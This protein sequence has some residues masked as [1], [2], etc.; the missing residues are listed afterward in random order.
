VFFLGMYVVIHFFN[1]MRGLDGVNEAFR[2]AGI[3]PFRGF[4]T[5]YALNAPFVAVL[6]LPF[7]ILMGAMW[8]V[9]HM[10]RRN[11]V[12]PVLSAGVSL[13]RMVLPLLAAGFLMSIL[14]AA[15]R[16]RVLP[17]LA[18]QRDRYDSLIKGQDSHELHEIPILIDGE[19]RRF[20]IGSY[21]VAA[22]V[23]R[24]ATLLGITSQAGAEAE[25]LAYDDSGPQ[26]PGWYP[27]PGTEIRGDARVFLE[28]DLLPIDLEAQSRGLLYL[29]VPGIRRLIQRDPGRPRLQVMLQTQYS[30]P[31]NGLI[32]LLLGLPLA[33]RTERR[34]PFIAAGMALLL[35]LV[36]F[37]VQSIVS[38]VGA[39][40]EVL[41]PVL[42]AWLPIV[43]F[44]AL[45]LILFESMRT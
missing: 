43:V 25:A 44:G 15:V 14:A 4:V 39:K 40:G 19:G 32:L 42:A 16:E 22:R 38:E 41:S 45:G 17:D 34:S 29:D 36:F 31:L 11:E 9:Q 1:R 27:V 37:A 33:L 35:S 8:T 28:T 13:K 21:D 18:L 2:T 24:R 5:Y 26:G 7:T 30:Y 23:A 12:V 10:G 20:N 6:M 3:S